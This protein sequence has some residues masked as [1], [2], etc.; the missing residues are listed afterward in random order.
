MNTQQGKEPVGLGAPQDV[1]SFYT[2][3]F[4]EAGP[5]KTLRNHPLALTLE[6]KP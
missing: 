6:S 4:K 2:K 5:K 1:G 3:F